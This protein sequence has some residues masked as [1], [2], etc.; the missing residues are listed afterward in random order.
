VKFK[1]GDIVRHKRVGVCTVIR[2]TQEVVRLQ[3]QNGSEFIMRL[4]SAQS[5]LKVIEEMSADTSQEFITNS[6]SNEKLF[7]GIDVEDSM[8]QSIESIE[9][10]QNLTNDWSSRSYQLEALA[11]ISTAFSKYDK[12]V[13]ALPTGSGK[14]YVAAKWICDNLLKY[15]KK[16]IWVAHRIE[17]L[18][19][20]YVTFVKLLPSSLSNDITWWAG[21]KSKNAHGKLVFV[22]IMGAYDFPEMDADLLVID[23]AHHEPATSYRR[24]I[25]KV[26]CKKHLGLTATPKRLDEKK[27]GYEAIAYQKTFMSLVAEGWLARPKPMVPKTGLSFDLDV[28]MDDFSEESLSQLDT[29]TR[30]NFIVDHWLE[31]KQE[32]GKTL[33]FAINKNHAKNLYSLFSS[34][35]RSLKVSYIVS[36]EGSPSD[37]ETEVYKFKNGQLDVLINC[38]IFTEGFDCPDVNTIFLTRPTMSITLYLQMIGRGT[39]VTETKKSFYIADFEDNLGKFQQ[40]LIRPWDLGDELGKEKS[41]KHKRQLKDINLESMSDWFRKDL[42]LKPIEL[43]LIAGYVEYKLESGRKDGFLVHID[44]EEIFLQIWSE[45]KDLSSINNLRYIINAATEYAIDT[46]FKRIPLQGFISSSIALQ[47]GEANYVSL[48]KSIIP[49]NVIDFLNGLDYD[50]GKLEENI[51]DLYALIKFEE[52]E[53]TRKVLWKEIYKEESSKFSYALKKLKDNIYL[54]GYNLRMLLDDIYRECMNDTDMNYYEWERF[55]M[56]IIMNPEDCIIYVNSE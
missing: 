17:L 24:L 10:D 33:V 44:D 46:R 2:I 35:D 52:D 16:V 28:R 30:N 7:S 15:Q 13:L 50:T 43:S 14:T 32:Y 38:R 37:R 54:R 41:N 53:I 18:Q 40:Q 4:S 27:L 56:R 3:N 20:A 9:I 21:G 42:E 11:A 26:G 25:A 5:D 6:E 36:G 19:Q 31:K 29:Q 49:E 45:L 22:S 1:V 55:S 12:I 39:R 23:E 51:D 8:I 34:K 47:R 48:W